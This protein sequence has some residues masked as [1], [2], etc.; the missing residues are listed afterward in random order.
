MRP[1]TLCSARTLARKP[2]E[3][4]R[5]RRRLVPSGTRRVESPAQWERKAAREPRVSTALA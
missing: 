3:K 1:I 2:R 5:P 4:R